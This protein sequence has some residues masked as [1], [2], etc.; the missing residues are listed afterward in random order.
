MQFEHLIILAVICKAVYLIAQFVMI[1]E[2]Q[3]RGR[4]RR[5]R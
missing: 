2:R 5:R 1:S 3:T 4:Q